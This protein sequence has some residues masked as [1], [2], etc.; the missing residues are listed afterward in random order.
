MRASQQVH[1]VLLLHVYRNSLLSTSLHLSQ[2]SS[3]RCRTLVFFPCVEV[4]RLNN[5][6]GVHIIVRVSHWIFL[7]YNIW[8]WVLVLTF[9]VIN[10]TANRS[11]RIP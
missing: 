11:L 5:Y 8:C 3:L 10:F 4:Q 9:C 1:R 6:L 2:L 7:V